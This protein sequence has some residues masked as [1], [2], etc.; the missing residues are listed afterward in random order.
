MEYRIKVNDKNKWI[1]NI[2]ES[3]NTEDMLV[4][5]VDCRAKRLSVFSG[6]IIT[7]ENSSSGHIITF[8]KTDDTLYAEN[9]PEEFSEIIIYG[10]SEYRFITNGGKYNTSLIFIPHSTTA[11]NI[12]GK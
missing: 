1:N 6:S 5:E 12:Y 7:G 11:K 10:I 3:K 2:F 4:L 8:F 9:N